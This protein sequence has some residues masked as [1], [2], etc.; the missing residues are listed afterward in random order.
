M[1]L[2]DGRDHLKNRSTRDWKKKNAM[3]KVRTYAAMGRRDRG[4]RPKR[5]PWKELRSSV[6]ELRGGGEYKPKQWMATAERGLPAKGQQ[7]NPN[8]YQLII[9]KDFCAGKIKETILLCGY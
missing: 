6:P 4:N 3:E 9:S 7:K 8:I 2:W 1:K 5:V